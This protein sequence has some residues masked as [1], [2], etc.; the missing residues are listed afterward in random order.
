[1]RSRAYDKNEVV[2]LTPWKGALLPSCC[3]EAEADETQAMPILSPM[4]LPADV[5]LTCVKC[6]AIETQLRESE[7]AEDEE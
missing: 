5:P 4:F 7:E 6:I 2:H 1:M 3:V